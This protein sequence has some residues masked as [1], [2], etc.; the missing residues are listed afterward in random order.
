M[1]DANARRKR[2]RGRNFVIGLIIV[3]VLL[4]AAF[5]IVDRVVRDYAEGQVK[6]EVAS[7][8]DLPSTKPVAV[9]LGDGSILVQA[10]L[11]SIN[12]ATI[13]VDPL[14]LDGITGT[15]TMTASDIP[16]DNSKPVGKLTVDIAIPVSSVESKLSSVSWL[17]PLDPQVTLNGQQV[18]VN[19][20]VN[21][22]GAKLPVAITLTPGVKAGEPTFAIDSAKVGTVTVPATALQ[23]Y[24]P[25]FAQIADLGDSV[26]IANALPKDLVLT[27]ITLTGDSAVYTLN[28]DGAELNSAAL[29]QKGTCPSS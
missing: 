24:I 9:D 25:G 13:T 22:F 5:F 2:H 20:S 17:K 16:L 12:K 1:Q 14:T 26:C 27:S 4:I 7:S 21:L 18:D 19:G 6:Q 23:N 10:A 8:L 29:S 11:G 15:A 3:I 28:G